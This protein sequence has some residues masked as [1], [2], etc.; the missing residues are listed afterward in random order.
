[1]SGRAP[2]RENGGAHERTRPGAPAEAAATRAGCGACGP[3]GGRA[4]VLGMRGGQPF[5]VSQK[6]LSIWAM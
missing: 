2:A 4:A 1:M 5:F 6:I 3:A